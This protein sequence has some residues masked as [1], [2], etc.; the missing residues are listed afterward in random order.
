MEAATPLGPTVPAGEETSTPG[1]LGVVEAFV[2][3]LE[4]SETGTRETLADPAAAT[5]WLQRYGLLAD[6]D[7]VPDEGAL[8]RL[9]DLR[10]ALRELAVANHDGGDPPPA[11]TGVLDAEAQNLALRID[12]AGADPSLRPMARGVDAAVGMLLVLV[13]DAM[14]DGS[15]QRFKACRNSSCQWAF[16]DASRN[17]SGKWCDMAG[18]GNRAKARNYRQRHGGTG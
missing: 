1:R 3:T 4:I 7:H 6:T 15:W 2:N 18:C 10:E 16:W 17:R 14:R 8:T 9:R 11:M 5:D 13:F 12:F